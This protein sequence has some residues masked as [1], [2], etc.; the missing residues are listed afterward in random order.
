[1]QGRSPKTRQI[2]GCLSKTV[3]HRIRCTGGNRPEQIGSDMKDRIVI[4]VVKDMLP[5]G[6]QA[7]LVYIVGPGTA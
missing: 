3:E 6:K 7:T 2:A 5:A 1:M 4:D